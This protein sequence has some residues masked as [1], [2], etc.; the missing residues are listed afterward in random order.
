MKTLQSPAGSPATGSDGCSFRIN[1]NTDLTDTVRVKE[2]KNVVLKEQTPDA[3]L[4]TDVKGRFYAA[5]HAE[6]VLFHDVLQTG[7]AMKNIKRKRTTV[8]P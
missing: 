1:S 8:S 2:M 3:A 6:P 7:T 5:V 4:F